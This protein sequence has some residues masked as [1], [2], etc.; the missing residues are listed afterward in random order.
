MYLTKWTIWQQVKLQSSTVI[1]VDW[2]VKLSEDINL[3]VLH[4]N[5]ATQHA[6]GVVGWMKSTLKL[7][8]HKR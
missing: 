5:N 3:Q 8:T 6:V 4:E 7:R 1:S 2:P